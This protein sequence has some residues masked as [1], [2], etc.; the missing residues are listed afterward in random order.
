MEGKRENTPSPEA[1]EL[2]LHRKLSPLGSVNVG[3]IACEH[4]MVLQPD[5]MAD[6]DIRMLCVTREG[7][8]LSAWGSVLILL[9]MPVIIIIRQ[10]F[11]EH[12]LHLRH[13]LKPSHQIL[14][15]SATSSLPIHPWSL[16]LHL[17]DLV[18]I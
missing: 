14:L 6:A 12:I 2:Q 16:D 15:S 3:S 11:T 10:M 7:S 18:L 17:T 5:T 4:G 8:I 13:V 1:Q 9:K